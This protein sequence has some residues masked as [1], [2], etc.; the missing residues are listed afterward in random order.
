MRNF[1]TRRQSQVLI[2]VGRL[3]LERWEARRSV[4]GATHPTSSRRLVPLF[5]PPQNC[6]HTY[7]PAAPFLRPA[8]NRTIYR[9][10]SRPAYTGHHF[11]SVYSTTRSLGAL[12]PRATRPPLGDKCRQLRITKEMMGSQRS[13]RT[14]IPCS[15]DSNVV[16]DAA[17]C[18]H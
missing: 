13:S 11:A 14:T 17:L 1:S 3:T 12:C 4:R 9:F 8:L 18:T 7:S 15:A 16:P 2:V 5:P 6:V 10:L